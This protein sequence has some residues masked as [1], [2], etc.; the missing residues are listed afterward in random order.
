VFKAKL[1]SGDQDRAPA[2]NDFGESVQQK[3]GAYA[4]SGIP[5]NI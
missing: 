4:K 2:D 5:K 3:L 1:F